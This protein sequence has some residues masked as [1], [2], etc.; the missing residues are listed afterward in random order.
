[1]Q[2]IMLYQCSRCDTQYS[3]RKAYRMHL[4]NAHELDMRQ[5]RRFTGE[6]FEN[7]DVIYQPDPAELER[8]R[9]W[10]RRSRRM[11]GL[12]SR[13]EQ[14]RRKRTAAAEATG[15]PPVKTSARAVTSP[16]VIR[17]PLDTAVSAEP[18]IASPSVSAPLSTATTATSTTPLP[19]VFPVTTATATL[20]FSSEPVV[21]SACAGA[22]FSVRETA[23]ACRPAG[24]HSSPSPSCSSVGSEVDES[25]FGDMSPERLHRI[26]D[27]TALE[28]ARGLLPG[29]VADGQSTA[30]QT[31]PVLTPTPPQPPSP[32]WISSFQNE[33]CNLVITQPRWPP[34]RIRRAALNNIG[35]PSPPTELRT[36]ADTIVSSIIGFERAYS[37]YL[38]A[39]ASIHCTN[40]V[41]A[42]LAAIQEFQQRIT[43][44]SDHY[45]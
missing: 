22:V 27:L 39:A 42:L 9:E 1:M 5:E 30:C 16:P 23:P 33:V 8:L 19:F 24:Y 25:V 28:E 4:I 43:R 40:P 41:G 15:A 12:R 45:L 36:L 29:R 32:E 14:R 44:P 11:G 2:I 6:K 7:I 31:D 34:S 35:L 10:W 21:T 38:S 37:G 17:C 3:S 20:S 18:A 13:T 26:D